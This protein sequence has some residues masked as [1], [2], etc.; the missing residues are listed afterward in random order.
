MTMDNGKNSLLSFYHQI[1]HYPV[2]NM[3]VNY[4]K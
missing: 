3:E 4:V 2:G 1:I